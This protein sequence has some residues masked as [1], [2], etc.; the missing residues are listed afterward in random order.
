MDQK[1][2]P[3]DYEAVRVLIAK[4]MGQPTERRAILIGIDGR[5]GAGKSSLASWLAWQFEMSTVHLDLLIAANE[6]PIAWHTEQLN[7]MI[8]SRLNRNSPVPII[9]EGI[10]LLKA[11]TDVGRNCDFLV[12]VENQDFTGSNSM[13]EQLERY[14]LDMRPKERANFVLRW[15]ETGRS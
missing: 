15:S 10:L 4:A 12:F 1:I 7:Q 2:A 3:L 9:V 13:R 6:V 8:A 11:L 5:D 14:F